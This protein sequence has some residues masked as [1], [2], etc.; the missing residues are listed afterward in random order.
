MNQVLFNDEFFPEVIATIEVA[1]NKCRITITIIIIVD[2]R[3][4]WWKSHQL[5]YLLIVVES[6]HNNRLA[7]EGKYK[8]IMPV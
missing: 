8:W 7:E 1:P 4:S 3:M 2:L 6:S 5:M